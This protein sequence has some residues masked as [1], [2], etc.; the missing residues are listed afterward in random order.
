MREIAVEALVEIKERRIS[1]VSQYP[2]DP[3]EQC[4]GTEISC[5]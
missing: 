1:N 4:P 3:G 5:R 2:G